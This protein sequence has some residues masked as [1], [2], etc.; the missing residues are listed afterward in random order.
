MDIQSTASWDQACPM[1]PVEEL[2][3]RAHTRR[4]EAAAAAAGR[5]SKRSSGRQNEYEELWQAG[6]YDEAG[7]WR[8][9]RMAQKTGRGVV[10][11]RKNDVMGLLAWGVG[12]PK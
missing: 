11:C 6:R 2:W 1:S 12:N 10:R 7:D 3:T 8:V 4:G 9:E 5:T